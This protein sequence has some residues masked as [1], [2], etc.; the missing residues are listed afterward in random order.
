MKRI[1]C[2]VCGSQ[3]IKKVSENTFECESCGIKYSSDNVK[4]LLVE[5]SGKV[6]IDKSSEIENMIKNGKRLYNSKSY[7]TAY[8][9]FN[10]ALN[11][12]AD[13]SE[14]V[15]YSGYS[16]ANMMIPDGKAITTAL[17]T[18]T[19]ATTI[20]FNKYGNTKEF[21]SFCA[22]AIDEML[23]IFDTTFGS[24]SEALHSAAF[25]TI[26]DNDINLFSRISYAKDSN[27]LL[28]G[29]KKIISIN[30][31]TFLTHFDSFMIKDFKNAPEEFFVQI[32]RIMEKQYFA[33]MPGQEP[34][35]EADKIRLSE[36][37][38]SKTMIS[39]KSE[40]N[41]FKRRLG[42]NVD[43]SEN[44]SEMPPSVALLLKN[45]Q[46][47]E[48]IKKYRE[49]TG[50]GLADAKAAINK[51]VSGSVLYST[52]TTNVTNIQKQSNNNSNKSG[53]I[54]AVV[55]FLIWFF[56]IFYNILK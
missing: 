44:N 33:N 54:A 4:K 41:S 14:A 35:I 8:S 47:I 20:Q 5:V 36:F 27:R 28:E 42:I 9:T 38:I 12:D 46:K 22:T 32:I 16:N 48:A 29:Y 56:I 24:Q 6:E 15:L 53:C 30:A 39:A 21:F 51:Y 11:I 31:G 18:A 50:A 45:G 1:Q 3:H 2:E 7:E 52:P 43:T 49:L 26:T 55:L 34:I 40:E 25:D 13:N 10:S 37:N 19:S 23:K 17:E